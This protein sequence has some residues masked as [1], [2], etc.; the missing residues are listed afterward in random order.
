M[1]DESIE[2]DHD[3]AEQAPVSKS[4]I[5]R[6]ML[7]LQ[8]L[9]ER[10]IKLKPALWEGLGL[11]PE[12]LDALR[13]SRRI[14]SHN[15]LR[16]HVRRL[17]KLLQ[18]EETAQVERLF[19]R[20]DRE[21][22]QDKAHFHR[23]ERWRERLLEGGDKVLGELMDACPKV[24]RQHLRQLVRGAQKERSEERPPVM[25]RKLFKYLR[26]LEFD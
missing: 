4:E 23:L 24:D 11:G 18:H 7:A 1:N 25:Q 15:A 9:G 20:M 14:K 8:A 10:L 13:E 2:A 6:E 16:R 17:G 12:M 19:A 5:K 26:G 22:L 21:Q 3:G